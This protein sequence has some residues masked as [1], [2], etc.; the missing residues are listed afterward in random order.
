MTKQRFNIKAAFEEAQAVQ[1][2]VDKE[3]ALTPEQKAIRD[4]ALQKAP[5][6]DESASAL[7]A[8]E[9]TEEPGEELP[10]DETPAE[11]V[12]DDESDDDSEPA[13]DEPSDIV[14]ETVVTETPED[15]DT[16]EDKEL[17]T[18][19]D[20]DAQVPDDVVDPLSEETKT[21]DKDDK[22]AEVQE[23]EAIKVATG[24]EAIAE[25]MQRSLDKGGLT[26][27]SAK[28][29]TLVV[30]QLFDRVGMTYQEKKFPAF[31]AYSSVSSRHRNTELAI[32]GISAGIDRVWQ[33]ITSSVKRILAK[34]REFIRSFAYFFRFQNGRINSI[35]STLGKLK[36]ENFKGKKFTSAS[37]IRDLSVGEKFNPEE[38]FKEVGSLSEHVRQKMIPSA[39]ANLRTLK[40]SVVLEKEKVEIAGIPEYVFNVKDFYNFDMKT[41]LQTDSSVT[42]ESTKLFLGKIEFSATMPRNTKDQ[43]L[44]AAGLVSTS[45]YIVKSND[46]PDTS[47]E[48]EVLELAKIDGFLT[49]TKALVDKQLKFI[50]DYDKI[51]SLFSNVEGL[52]DD[53]SR[54]SQGSNNALA[55]AINIAVTV[56]NKRNRSQ[57][58]KNCILSLKAFEKSFYRFTYQT[59]ALTYEVTHAAIAY[60][61][62]S[63][64]AYL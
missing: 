23:D 28:A 9:T 35:R 19:N 60:A 18:E 39:V 45:A 46:A 31:E 47:S 27:M 62:S 59:S 3:A 48:V 20:P 58:K 32:E 50:N 12:T 24:L 63:A 41:K 4:E 51:E 52:L 37:A 26:Q 49:Q 43:A 2:E 11:P 61:N 44:Y 13:S 42:Y 6:T 33:A 30:K 22:A 7:A 53:T 8:A 36:Q 1:L 34:M 64:K 40:S 55:N 16:K 14:E 54:L 15:A 10:T 38:V 17:V 56:Y 25:V 57:T 29:G 5:E 21:A